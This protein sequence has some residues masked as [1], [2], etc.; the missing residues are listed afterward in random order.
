MR[1]TFEGFVELELNR[2]AQLTEAYDELPISNITTER[3]VRGFFFPALVLDRQ[4]GLESGGFR[5]GEVD[6]SLKEAGRQSL[7]KPPQLVG[8]EVAT[9]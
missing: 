5:G 3:I 6:D 2:L 9:I 7:N 8:R 4:K 1:S